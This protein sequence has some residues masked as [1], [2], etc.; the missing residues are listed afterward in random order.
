MKLEIETLAKFNHPNIIRMFDH[1]MDANIINPDATSIPVS[2]SVLELCTGELYDFVSLSG[3]FDEPVAR[4]Y[5]RQLI[6][7]L[8]HAHKKG[9]THRDLK[10]ENLLL[11]SR[12][13]LKIADFGFAA[14]I[15]GRENSGGLLKT[16][17]GSEAYM[18]PE[19][20]ER[21]PYKGAEVDLFAAGIIL[22]TIMSGHPPIRKATRDDNFYRLMRANN[23]AFW[24]SH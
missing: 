11:D 18:A 20:H 4:F 5:F 9:I 2:Y 17:L 13:N 22:F 21:K 1:E 7:G 15:E 23:I 19:I 14:P 3:K 12:F 16:Y 10:P 6:D 24:K 8:N